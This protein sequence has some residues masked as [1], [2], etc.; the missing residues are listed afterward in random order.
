[1]CLQHTDMGD[2]LNIT[3]GLLC[4][5]CQKDPS[6]RRIGEKALRQ[7]EDP[8]QWAE[9]RCFTLVHTYFLVVSKNTHRYGAHVSPSFFIEFCERQSSSVDFPC[10][11]SVHD[12]V[13]KRQLSES[14]NYKI[15]SEVSRAHSV[16]RPVDSRQQG[17]H[18]AAGNTKQTLLTWRKRGRNT[19][20]HLE[21][22]DHRHPS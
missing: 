3:F 18:G 6:L 19:R 16:D 17:E 15:N 8:P 1:M 12:Q 2:Y 21:S 13:W 4:F 9:F 22:S 11:E 14:T 20:S 7:S 10:M 5:W